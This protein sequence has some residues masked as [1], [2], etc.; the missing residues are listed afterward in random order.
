[1][2]ATC[3][4]SVKIKILLGKKRRGPNINRWEEIIQECLEKCSETE[5]KGATIVEKRTKK[6][7]HRMY[8]HAH[9]PVSSS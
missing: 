4:H 7:T 5:A 9:A 8:A 2:T 3:D 6:E 1:M